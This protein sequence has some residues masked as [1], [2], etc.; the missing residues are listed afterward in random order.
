MHMHAGKAEPKTRHERP[1]IGQVVFASPLQ[2]MK[3][4]LDARRGVRR[5]CSSWSLAPDTLKQADA[6]PWRVASR[7][8]MSGAIASAA[9][10]LP[11]FDLGGMA[12]LAPRNPRRG[13]IL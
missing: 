3:S 2:K 9:R 8:L 5:I 7:G 4:D 13:A 1:P 10:R 12:E 11:K 6:S